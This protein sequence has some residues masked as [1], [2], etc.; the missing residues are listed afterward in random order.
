[1]ADLG[2][3]LSPKSVA[4]VGAAPQGQGLRGRIVE[5]MRAHPYAGKVYPVSRTHREIQGLAAYPSIG[6]VPV[7]VDLSVL[8]IPAKFVAEELEHC[9]KAGVKS[10]VVISSGFAE[11]P[12]EA[13]ANMQS[14]LRAIARRYGMAVMGPNSEGFANLDAALCPTFSPAVTPS[15]TPLLPAALNN[16]RVAVIA[17]SGGMGFSFFDRGRPKEMA[18][19]YIITTGN[20]ACLETFDVVEHLLEEGKT[21]AFLLLLEDIK[22]AETFRR[23]AAKALKAGKP[24][25]VNKIGQS[26]AGRRA[27]ASHTAALAGSYSAFQAMAR[28]YGIIEGGDSEE[29]VDIAQ[30]FLRSGIAQLPAGRRV[31]ICTASGGGGGWM[32]DACIA[33]GLEVPTLD[34]ETRRN[35]DK[36]LPSYG[37][38]QN[39]IDGTAQAIHALGYAGMAELVLDSPSIDSVIVVMSGR[40]GERVVAER[41]RLM[42][43]KAA[44]TKPIL[45]WSYTL[46]VPHTLTTLAETGYPI[47]TNMRNCART[48]AVMTDYRAAREAALRA[49]DIRTTASAARETVATALKTSPVA[50]TEAEARPLLAAYGIGS[51]DSHVVT[52]V[53]AAVAAFKAIGQPV[54][55]K[56]QSPDILHKTEAGAVALKLATADDVR[57]AYERVLENAKRYA[58]AANIHGVLVQPMAPAG[59]E[60]ILGINR[61]DTFGP[62]LMLGLGGIHVEVLKDVAFAPVPLTPEAATALIRRLRGAALL[63]A[64]RGQPAADIPALADL[65]VRLSQFTA[66]HADTV[67]EIDLNPVLVHPAGQGATVVDALIVKRD[68]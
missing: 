5:I 30:G 36:H 26:D 16:G 57:S 10:A 32:A 65:M 17:Q 39:P 51:G 46:P 66:D 12:G 35:V 44:S 63:D 22:T 29:M 15:A 55:L 59:R 43:V 48:L 24:I 11:E 34:A 4:I 7:P 9:G 61:D 21:D 14:E 53:D 58:P 18:F 2:A 19:N 52:S 38:S 67:K 8:I 25:I 54:V 50:L 42:R 13:G 40:A 56:V 3:M 6:D 23:V 47:F 20:E 33:A 27:A 60:V 45:M 37:T 31:A 49:P 1:M 64:H 62:L 41:D 68:T 28:H